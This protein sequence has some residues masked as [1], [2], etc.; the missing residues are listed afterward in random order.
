[1]TDITLFEDNSIREFNFRQEGWVIVNIKIKRI[2][3]ESHIDDG[4]RILVDRIWP[5]GISK[6]KANLDEWLK[7][8]APSKELRQWFNHEAE[9]FQQFSQQYNAELKNGEQ[10]E[11]YERLREI[12]NNHHI[13]TLLYAAKDEEHNQAIVLQQMLLGE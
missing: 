3:E 8:V 7:E 2:Y 13:V 4:K 1:M 9:K 5:R 11:S 6:E 12:A 10:K